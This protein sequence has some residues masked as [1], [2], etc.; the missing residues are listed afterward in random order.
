[1][2]LLYMKEQHVYRPLAA[3][4]LFIVTSLGTQSKRVAAHRGLLAPHR[5]VKHPLLQTKTFPSDILKCKLMYRWTPI[6]AKQLLCYATYAIQ[7]SP[8]PVRKEKRECSQSQVT[9]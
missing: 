7:L 1:M 5:R 3:G 4:N 2:D 8:F 6:E 9:A